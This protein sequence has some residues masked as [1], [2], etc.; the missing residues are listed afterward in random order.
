MLELMNILVNHNLPKKHVKPKNS[1]VADHLLFCSHSSILTCKNKR[2][3]LELK[4]SLLVMRDLSSLN[5]EITSASLYLFDGAWIFVR[6]LFVLIVA[7]VLLNG[8][9]SHM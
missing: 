5:R 1:S 9:F 2:F 4:E 7:S 6:I 3:L 8:R